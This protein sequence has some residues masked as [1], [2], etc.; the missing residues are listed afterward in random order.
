MTAFPSSYG[1]DAGRYRVM[2]EDGSS[3]TEADDGS[4]RIQRLYGADQYRIS[5]ELFGLSLDDRA[6]LMAF[7]D[8]NRATQVEWTDP[9]T[10]LVYDVLMLRPPRV[11]RV[12][13]LRM[14]ISF[15][16]RGTQR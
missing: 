14:S 12:Y 2:P 13:G 11:E 3:V 10:G 7:Y 15:E 16:L 4:T 9:F 1:T 8:T 5:F 6:A